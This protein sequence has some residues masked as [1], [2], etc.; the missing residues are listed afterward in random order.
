MKVIVTTPAD[1]PVTI[2]V[3][4]T[5]AIAPLL[6]LH[7]PPVVASLSGSVKPTVTVLPPDIGEGEGFTVTDKVPIQPVA[8]M[9]VIVA[10]PA[11]RP[12]AMPDDT[13]TTAGLL[14]LQLL[15]TGPVS[16]SVL[17]IQRR[18]DPL[19]VGVGYTVTI[20]VV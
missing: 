6:L 1:T 7:V 12:M 19:I 8:A 4:P 17:P 13:E 3:A 5:V 14:V 10:T 16:V 11:E 15:P 18:G 9:H 20:A 2:P